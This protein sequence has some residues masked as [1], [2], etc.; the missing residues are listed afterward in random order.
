MHIIKVHSREGLHLEDV[1]STDKR[2]Y[3]GHL[4]ETKNDQ[5]KRRK[6]RETCQVQKMPDMI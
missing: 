1:I 5:G 3:G 4:K 2:E 6:K